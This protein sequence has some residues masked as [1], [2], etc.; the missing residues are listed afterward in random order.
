[1]QQL[2]GRA[3][4]CGMP[5]RCTTLGLILLGVATQVYAEVPLPPHMLAPERWADDNLA[6]GYVGHASVLIKMTGTFVLTDPAFNDR[7][8]VTVGPLTIGPQRVVKPALPVRQV[9][10][11]AAVLITHAHFDSLDLSSLRQLAHDTTLIAPPKCD[12]LLADLGFARYVELGWGERIAVGGV[13]IEAVPVNHWGKRYP[14]DGWRGYN[15]YL[16][17]KD[18]ANVL[19][20]SDTAYTPEFRRFADGPALTVAILGTGAYDPWVRNHANPE[21]VWQMFRESHAQFLIPVHWDTFRLGQE[22][23]GDAM[24]RLL[25][26][27]GDDADR[28]VIREIGGEWSWRHP[29]Q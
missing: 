6:V 13:S 25:A 26:A 28:V 14:W 1:L 9:P 17:S 5:Q 7:V 3:H 21:Q 22:P 27:A 8:G 11:L 4:N 15:G 16:L 18:G 24:R 10:N 19:F 23:L 29:P 20:A 12:D 2:M